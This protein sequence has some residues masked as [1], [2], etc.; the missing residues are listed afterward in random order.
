M[1]KINLKF[2]S[3]F[4]FQ[5]MT[6]FCVA[7]FCSSVQ[8]QTQ[9]KEN[10]W[11]GAYGQLGL[12]G[13]TSYIPGTSGGTTSIGS[14]QLPTTFSANNLNGYAANVS[15][16][17]NFAINGSYLLGI[18]ATLFPGTSRSS[19]TSATNMAGTVNGEY[20]L[21]NLFSI[22]L[23]PAY[24]IDSEKLLYGKIGYAGATL[25][26]S[27][28]GNRAGNFSQVSMNTNGVVFGLGYKQIVMGSIY[29]FAEANYAINNDKSASLVTD[30]GLIV[31]STA[32]AT[33]FD[34]M[35]GVGYRF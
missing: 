30:D 9:T 35:F 10:P 2:A 31:S 24:A 19:T 20:N 15:A 13:Y 33:G 23:I 1:K 12:L 28:S 17:Y 11:Q 25:K 4:A 26:T 21:S 16:G 14:V 3:T 8:A 6:F 18:G 32:K 27:A 34:L 22:Y 5:I 7:L 29:L